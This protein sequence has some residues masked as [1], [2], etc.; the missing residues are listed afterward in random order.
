M[1]QLIKMTVDF[2]GKG[3]DDKNSELAPKIAINVLMVVFSLLVQAYLPDPDE[4]APEEIRR[5]AR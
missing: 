4:K 1:R 3:L 5:P 2:L